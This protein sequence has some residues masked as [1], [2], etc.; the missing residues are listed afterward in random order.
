MPSFRV[1][2]FVRPRRSFH[3]LRSFHLSPA[4]AS[5]VTNSQV[6]VGDTISPPLQSEN[7][8]EKDTVSMVGIVRPLTARMVVPLRGSTIVTLAILASLSFIICISFAFIGS[9]TDVPLFMQTLNIVAETSP[10]VIP[11]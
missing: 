2:S 5:A 4:E 9:D 10:G 11:V 7:D 1:P 3:R 8:K 6:P